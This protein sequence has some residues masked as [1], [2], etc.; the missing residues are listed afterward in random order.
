MAGSATPAAPSTARGGVLVIDKPPGPTSHDIVAVVRRRLRGAKVGHTGTL[1]PLATG[2][3]PLVV[4][5][6]TRLAQHFAANEKEYVAGIRFGRATDTHDAQGAVVFEAP[7]GQPMPERETLAS[8]VAGYAGTW[9][10]T[11]PAYSAKMSDG[12]RAYDQARKGVAVELAPVPVTVHAVELQAL[13]GSLATIRL[14][15]S[16]GF[17]VRSFAHDLG[18]R[19]GLGAHLEGLRRTRSGEFDLSMAIT[20]DVVMT[21]DPL[22]GLLPLDQ[23]LAGWT[24][25]VL[26]PQGVD[27]AGHGRP[28]G[29]AQ[30]QGGLPASLEAGTRVRLTGPDGTLL[31]LASAAPGGL[32]HPGVVLV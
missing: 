2:V 23:L 6:A 5:K 12:H 7:A 30:C 8:L 17:Y 14:V 32:L 24:T 29:P 22:A 20:L 4:G 27:W 18:L 19:L 31:A 15:T 13:K 11:P 26:T 9:D 1:D 21:G 25:V 3:L 16:A 10:Q 28:L